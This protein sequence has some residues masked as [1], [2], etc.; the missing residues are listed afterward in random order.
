[1]KIIAQM[2]EISSINI[3]TDSTFAILLEAQNQG[4]EIFYYLPEN[5]TYDCKNVKATIHKIKLQNK[6]GEHYEILTTSNEN[7]TNF[8]IILIRQDPPF[9]INYITS[10]YLLEIIKDK[11]LIINNP[12]EIR[13][14]PEKI[15]VTNFKEFIPPT[16]ISSNI[17]EIKKFKEKHKDIII[18]P[19]YGAGGEGVF[20]L[21]ENDLNLNVITESALKLYKAPIIAQ[22]FI[23]EVKNGDK[24]ILLLNG[25]FL[26]AVTRVSGKEDI[27]S[28]FHAG[29]A[30]RKS[31]L[32]ERDKEICQKIAPELKKRGLFFVGIDVIGDYLTEIN[33]TSPTGIQEINH[34]NNC[35][36]EREII[37]FFENILNN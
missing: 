25:E 19:L 30:A 36:I 13:N 12:S 20:Y 31:I 23:K 18:K 3:K 10:T 32:S 9:D 2:D 28:N 17:E 5:L 35:K 15:F 8:D 29:G 26:G 24:R 22:K 4:H 7:L 14:C 21:Q 33:V 6:I 16:I 34:L 37:K 1:M 27:R 11:V